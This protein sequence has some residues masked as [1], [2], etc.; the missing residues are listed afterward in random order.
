MTT[1]TLYFV[2]ISGHNLPS[3]IPILETQPE[4]VVL[5]VTSFFA[6]KSPPEL[7][8]QQ[9]K[10][11]LPATEI[12]MLSSENL[13]G[14]CLTEMEA[15]SQK[16]FC[17]YFDQHKDDYRCILNM[18]GG[19]K[20]LP[21]VLETLVDWDEV[22]Y[23]GQKIEFLQ[24]WQVKN[25]TRVPLDNLQLSQIPPLVG[26][27]LY[28][29]T[30]EGSTNRID[31]L[32]Q[33][34]NTAQVIWNYYQDYADTGTENIHI[35]L[36][37]RLADVWLELDKY[38]EKKV[39]IPW[40]EFDHSPEALAPWL[41]Q[42][43]TLTPPDLDPILTLSNHGVEIPGNKLGSSKRGKLRDD[44]KDWI[45]GL[46][47]ETLTHTWLQELN[48]EIAT[49][50]K[51]KNR[52]RELDFVLMHQHALHVIEAKAAPS[53]QGAPSDIIRQIKSV[54]AIGMLQNYLLISPYFS[55]VD[56]I[57]AQQFDDF[58]KSCKQNKIKLLSSK[59]E[60]LDVFTPQ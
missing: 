43:S 28:T 31:Q 36:S 34:A 51:I 12:E 57:K 52:K 2:I 35:D 32:P 23:K 10:N 48:I 53:P 6:G 42:L 22:H 27:N 18:T 1:P 54:D 21:L 40:S 38:Q 5:I 29:E 13:G 30:T 56:Y 8:K 44:W 25:K 45:S 24:R 59:E 20:I 58:K 7:F 37:K 50:V 3:L 41:K 60:L 4:K 15:W 55:K 33:A 11:N 39:M 47:L 49:S 46:W 9:I 16:H 26:L 17:P 14:E 19:T